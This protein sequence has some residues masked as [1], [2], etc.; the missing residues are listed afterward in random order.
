[1]PAAANAIEIHNAGSA[2]TK[3]LQDEARE[4]GLMRSEGK[5]YVVQDGKVMIVDR[6]QSDGAK[7]AQELGA[8]VLA[9]RP[10]ESEATLSFA[11]LTDLLEEPAESVSP[12]M[13]RLAFRRASEALAVVDRPPHE[14]RER[15][16]ALG[17]LAR[18]AG[19][20]TGDD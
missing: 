7:L 10:A 13:V 9:A 1:M 11:G 2:W 12:A 5:E 8:C 19:I 20:V 17:D 15:F 14:T 4:Q 3:A 18:L 6:P 16:A